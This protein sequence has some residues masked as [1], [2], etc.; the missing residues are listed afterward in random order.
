MAVVALIAITATAVL[1]AGHPLAAVGACGY[2]AALA[3]LSDVDLAEHRLPNNLVGPLAGAVALWLVAA[4][5]V[6]DDVGRSVRALAVGLAVAAAFLAVAMV[7]DLGMGDV[8]LAL[9]VAMVAGWLGARA[10]E[11]TVVAT[12]MSAAVGAAV[13]IGR[14]RSRHRNRNADRDGATARPRLPFGPFLALGAVAGVLVAAP[15]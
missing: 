4:G 1:W 8:K 9:P 5:I 10:G 12:G 3:V 6:G 2:L 7:G 14:S 15:R 11:A 13:L